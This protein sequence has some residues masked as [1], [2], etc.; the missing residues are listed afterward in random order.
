M[1]SSLFITHIERH[2]LLP[3][4]LVVIDRLVRCTLSPSGKKN[5]YDIVDNLPGDVLTDIRG[6]AVQFLIAFPN[7]NNPNVVE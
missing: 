6:L 1:P 7:I 5:K 3:K 4:G 2:S